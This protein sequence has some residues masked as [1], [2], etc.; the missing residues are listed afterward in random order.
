MKTRFY[1]SAIAMLISLNLFGQDINGKLGTNG[2][3]IIRD[4]SSTFLTVS[5]STGNLSLNRNLIFTTMT[6]GSRL[7]N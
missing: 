6:A 2:Q 7:R 3:F 1:L 5:Q 4:T